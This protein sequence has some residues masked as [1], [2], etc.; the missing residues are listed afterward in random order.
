MVFHSIVC[1]RVYRSAVRECVPV[2]MWAV[3]ADN[4]VVELVVVAAIGSGVVQVPLLIG[5]VTCL[6][7]HSFAPE[8]LGFPMPSLC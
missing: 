1:L 8:V 6:S 5:V 2:D 4:Y 3:V 7:G